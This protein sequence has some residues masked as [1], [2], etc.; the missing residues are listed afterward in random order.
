MPFSDPAIPIRR[1]CM[2]GIFGMGNIHELPRDRWLSSPPSLGGRYLRLV[3]FFFFVQS[4]CRIGS[5]A[6][7]QPAPP[8][9]SSEAIGG[10]PMPE[11][12]HTARS[13]APTREKK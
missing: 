10:A 13:R 11:P 4:I 5:Y 12:A 2:W 8:P 6:R 3:F 7:G 1:A 9:K